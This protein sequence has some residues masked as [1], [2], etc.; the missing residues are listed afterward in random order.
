MES[1]AAPP[2]VL[3]AIVD[4]GEVETE[5]LR[6]GRGR[7]VVYLGGMLG[8]TG[9]R[10]QIVAA[11][12][13]RFRVIAPQSLSVLA[14]AA[15]DEGGGA[16]TRWLVGV[17]DGLGIEAASFVVEAPLAVDTAYF[18]DAFALRVERLVL[19]GVPSSAQALASVPV[20]AVRD[21]ANAAAVDEIL[22]FLGSPGQRR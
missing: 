4:S 16:F 18:A 12:A 21:T 9:P 10:E 22:E 5:Y 8:R 2:A 6:A 7:T 1:S 13:S 11:L 20:L 17:L 15:P 19:L 3:R 14:I